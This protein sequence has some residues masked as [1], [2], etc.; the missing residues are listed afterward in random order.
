MMVHRVAY[1]IKTCNVVASLAIN[2]HQT[3]IHLVPHVGREH[4]KRR[5]QKTYML[6]G[7]KI[8]GKLL[9]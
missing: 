8:I 6:L 5:D 7:L 4:G 3:K 1:L 2:I 9:L